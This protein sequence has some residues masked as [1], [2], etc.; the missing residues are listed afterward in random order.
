MQVGLPGCP[1]QIQGIGFHAS[2]NLYVSPGQQSLF[3]SSNTLLIEGL[4][5]SAWFLYLQDN[6]VHE[7][8]T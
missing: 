6:S 4:V 8:D 5:P 3:S 1:K 7:A 2:D